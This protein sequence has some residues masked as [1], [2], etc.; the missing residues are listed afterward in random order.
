M[1]ALG[2]GIAN[3]LKEIG[4]LERVPASENEDGHVQV[5]DLVII[6]AFCFLEETAIPGYQPRI[7]LVDEA[8]RPLPR[9]GKR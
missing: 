4:A 9:L 5:G 8:N 1:H 6:A 3:Q 2:G 7:V